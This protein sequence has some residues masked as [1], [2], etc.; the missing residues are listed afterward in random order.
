MLYF[1]CDALRQV[2]DGSCQGLARGLRRQVKES[3]AVSSCRL[4]FKRS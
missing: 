3:M 4:L 2:E 1:A